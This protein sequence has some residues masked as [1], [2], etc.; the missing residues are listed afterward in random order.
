MHCSLS[1]AT[2]AIVSKFVVYPV[3][4]NAVVHIKGSCVFPSVCMS[5]VPYACYSNLCG[6]CGAM[7]QAERSWVR[8]PIRP[9]DFSIDLILPAALWPW[10]QLS[11]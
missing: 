8:F 6:G 10:G 1:L 4:L 2:L 11:L 9:L 5:H 3:R 7:L